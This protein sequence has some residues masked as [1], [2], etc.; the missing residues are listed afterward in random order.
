MRCGSLNEFPSQNDEAVA[1]TIWG[2][3]F[4]FIK[5]AVAGLSPAQVVPGRLVGGTVLLAL[6]MVLTRRRWPSGTRIWLH[7]VAIGILMCVA[8]F[9][10]F[11][12]A[13]QYLPSGLSSIFNA[14]T[15]IAT[16][17]IA[18]TVLPEERLTRIR[19]VAMI[20][21]AGGIVLVLGP[22]RFLTEI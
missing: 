18:F 15:P 1:D 22:W 11:S 14:T 17:L 7:L 12:W 20:I 5:V 10:L 16:M 6:I 2:A 19:S 8:P 21:A 13:A 4:L 9:L 3:S